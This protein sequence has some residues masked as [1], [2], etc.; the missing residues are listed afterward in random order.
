MMSNQFEINQE[1]IDAQVALYATTI[2]PYEKI[3]SL[4]VADAFVKFQSLVQEGR[5]LFVND[6]G[7]LLTDYAP[8]FSVGG[9]SFYLRRRQ[10][11]IDA[12]LAAYRERLTAAETARL[13]AAKAAH[14][15]AQV[16]AAIAAH[17]AKEAEKA[18][19]AKD[20]VAE[21]ARAAAI[22]AL[23]EAA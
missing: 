23:G 13:Q 22:A 2:A 16:A 9:G 1:A 20:Q 18:Q 4:S 3:T 11:D 6:K 8:A 15:E 5:E 19:R 14:I 17:E 10:E 12:E 21:K 7:A